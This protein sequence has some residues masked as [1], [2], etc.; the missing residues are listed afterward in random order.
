MGFYLSRARSWLFCWMPTFSLLLELAQSLIK[1]TASNKNFFQVTARGG[2]FGLEKHEKVWEAQAGLAGFLRC[3]AKE[4]PEIKCRILDFE[5]YSK[6]TSAED[7]AGHLLLELQQDHGFEEVGYKLDE[8]WTQVP[9]L[10]HPINPQ[11]DSFTD[12]QLRPNDVVVVTGGARGITATMVRELGSKLPLKFVLLGR[13]LVVPE[14]KDF[15][16]APG[17]TQNE[18]KT[19]IFSALKASGAKVTPREVERLA[20][21]KIAIDEIEDQLNSLNDYGCVAKYYSVDVQLCSFAESCFLEVTN[22]LGPIRGLIHGAGVLRDKFVADK[23]LDQFQQVLS[24]KSF[25]FVASF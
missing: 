5:P 20:N 24:T 21:K 6:D 14:L 7:R 25:G 13:S 4:H 18:L 12:L 2:H 10:E 17:L 19:K 15:D 8:R 16:L 3:F 9:V 22:D 11:E 1:S 23:T